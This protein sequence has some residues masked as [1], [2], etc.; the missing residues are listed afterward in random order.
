MIL[1]LLYFTMVASANLIIWHFGPLATIPVAFAMIGAT[2]TLRDALHLRWEGP[3]LKARMA[4]LIFVAGLA[5]LAISIILDPQPFR[6]A[7]FSAL[8]TTLP[9]RIAL[10]SLSAFLVSESLDA[11]VFT[12]LR[13]HGWN[14]RA[15]GSN[16][17][18][19]AADSLIFPMI[20]FGGFP[21]GIIVGQFAAK[22]L[23][24]AGW[25]WLL[26]RI[27]IRKATTRDPRA[28]RSRPAASAAEA[29]A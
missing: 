12:R 22:M 24:G 6:T 28:L 1:I 5:S 11:W 27:R 29:I 26:S 20:A 17:V 3:G 21:L 15:N 9:G 18:S 8:W 23:G 7:G 16:L 13:G 14:A 4:A 10:G 2:I 19:A 25:V